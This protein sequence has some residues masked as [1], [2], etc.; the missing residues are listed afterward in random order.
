[1][2]VTI[3]SYLKNIQRFA[4]HEYMM[5]EARRSTNILIGWDELGKY[6]TYSGG[7]KYYINEYVSEQ[8]N[9]AQLRNC[10]YDY[11]KDNYEIIMKTHLK[12]IGKIK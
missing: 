9:Y 4:E 2:K 7:K 11:V 8:S 6:L 3:S 10:I 1:M 12:F 5:F